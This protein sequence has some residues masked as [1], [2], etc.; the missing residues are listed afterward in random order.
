M[1][2]MLHSCIMCLVLQI[3]NLTFF[4]FFCFSGKVSW[5]FLTLPYIS[6][7]SCST[8]PLPTNVVGGLEESGNTP[9]NRKVFLTLEKFSKLVAEGY[10]YYKQNSTSTHLQSI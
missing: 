9:W 8:V 5:K 4:F 6:K 7:I 3:L 1:E 10:M 2:L